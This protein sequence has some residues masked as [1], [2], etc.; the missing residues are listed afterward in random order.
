MVSGAVVAAALTALF[1][2]GLKPSGMN[3]GG[4]VAVSMD[5]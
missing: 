2:I 3:A 4:I 5:D 1:F